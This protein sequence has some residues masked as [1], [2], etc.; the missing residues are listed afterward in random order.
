METTLHRVLTNK[1]HQKLEVDILLS[2]P[3]GMLLTVCQNESTQE[4]ITAALS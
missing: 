1:L 3:V 2:Q 4:D